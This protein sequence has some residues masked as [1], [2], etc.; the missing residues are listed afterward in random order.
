MRYELWSYDEYGQ[1][2]ILSSSTELDSVMKYAVNYLNE[3]NVDNPLTDA[4]R[5]KNWEAFFPVIFKRGQ[6]ATNLLY[7]GDRRN[8]DREL[9]KKNGNK[10]ELVQDRKVKDKFEYR[11]LLGEIDANGEK[12]DWYLKDLNKTYVTSFDNSLLNNK[13]VLFI[14]IV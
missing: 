3:V 10:W 13:V 8:G 6:V 11:F 9:Y 5:E 2:N 4:E 7:A 1:G 12:T 14:K